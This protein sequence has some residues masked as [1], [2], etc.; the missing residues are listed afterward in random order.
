MRVQ[1]VSCIDQRAENGIL[2]AEDTVESR[3]SDKIHARGIYFKMQSSISSVSSVRISQAQ[4]A[5][6][7]VIKVAVAL[8][9]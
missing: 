5:R 3:L 9:T 6:D 1:S 7:L 2:R 4:E 8:Q